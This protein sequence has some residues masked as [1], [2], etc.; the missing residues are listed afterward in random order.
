MNH[1]KKYSN[2]FLFLVISFGIFIYEISMRLIINNES[3]T[4]NHNIRIVIYV[5][6]IVIC[7]FNVYRQR[8]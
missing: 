5:Y 7:L 8:K 3:F 4:I 2:L 1:N 6:C